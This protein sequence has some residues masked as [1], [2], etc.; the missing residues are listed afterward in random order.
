[1]PGRDGASC[2]ICSASPPEATA[3]SR[4][5]TPATTAG[6]IST[7]RGG[8]KP[9]APLPAPKPVFPRYVEPEGASQGMTLID[10]HC[11]LDFPDFADEIEDVVARAEAGG[12]RSG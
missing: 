3:T 5:S 4:R 11:H 10:S 2:S 12:R 1:M 9:G 6:R 7:R 8:C